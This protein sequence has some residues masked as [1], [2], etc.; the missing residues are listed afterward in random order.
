MSDLNEVKKIKIKK[1]Q[2]YSLSVDYNFNLRFYNNEE[3]YQFPLIFCEGDIELSVPKREFVLTSFLK[4]EVFTI[5]DRDVIKLLKIL[6]IDLTPFIWMIMLDNDVDIFYDRK[7]LYVMSEGTFISLSGKTID[8]QIIERIHNAQ[9]RNNYY[10]AYNEINNELHSFIMNMIS[11]KIYYS[12]LIKRESPEFKIKEKEIEMLLL[13]KEMNFPKILVAYEN[14]IRFKEDFVKRYF[15][16]RPK[17]DIELF[18]AQ[19]QEIRTILMK[20]Q[21]IEYIV[22]ET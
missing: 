10:G 2:D 1:Y 16:M 22:Y 5:H 7:E 12:D 13:S 19:L 6:K 21:R 15:E 8:H 17:E 11:N 20:H 3:N 18:H 14:L 4:K 9:F